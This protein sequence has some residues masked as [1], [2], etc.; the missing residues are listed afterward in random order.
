ME[1]TPEFDRNVENALWSL[2]KHFP[3]KIIDSFEDSALT[4]FIYENI[5]KTPIIGLSRE[6]IQTRI[7]QIKK[8]RKNLQDLLDSPQVKQRSPE[9]FELRKERLTAS[10]TA[11][12]IGKGKFGNRNQLL[13]T[14]A[15]PE[16]QKWGPTTS[17]PMYHGTMLEAMSSRCYAQRNNNMLIYDFGM[18]K[19]PE[20]SCYGASP[21]GIT[22]V[23]IMVEIKTP[24][25][26]KVDGTIPEE[27][28]LQMQGQMAV[29]GLL[30][31]DFVDCK[32]DIL[33]DQHTYMRD[34]VKNCTL[35]HGVIVETRD[36]NG[37]PIFEYSPEN[38]TSTEC[39]QWMTTYCKTINKT[40]MFYKISYW[41][42]YKIITTRVYFDDALWQSLIPQ[43]ELFWNDVLRYRIDKPNIV[44]DS[45]KKE[46]DSKKVKFDFID[47]DED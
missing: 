47:S 45:P 41:K 12:A 33:S 27:Y 10:A 36:E 20:L 39:I 5:S 37:N 46:K 35:D 6:N 28:M 25:R 15:F 1:H 40:T 44:S 3:A 42:M 34:I 43:I 8:Y 4:E 11:Q 30:E 29:C 14:K 7:Q 18:I 32:I 23:G 2:Y 26:R 9:W 17:G 16:N 22:E 31:C 24:W 21:D 19:H 38:L 13:N